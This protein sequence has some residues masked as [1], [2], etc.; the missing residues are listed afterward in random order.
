MHN[1]QTQVT[2]FLMPRANFHQISVK[3]LAMSL[4]PS[5]ESHAKPR[6]SVCTIREHPQSELLISTRTIAIKPWKDQPIEKPN[7]VINPMGAIFTAVSIAKV[8]CGGANLFDAS[9][10]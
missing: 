4:V 9:I 10:E 3:Y 2:G 8:Y 7:W 5:H 6:C 1:P